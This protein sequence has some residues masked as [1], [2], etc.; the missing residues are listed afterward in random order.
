MVKLTN[1]LAQ[2]VSILLHPLLM[3]IFGLLIIYT[4]GTYISLLQYEAKRIILIVVA[5]NTI[6]LPLLI[7]PLFYRLGFIKNLQMHIHKERILP[8]AFT[9]I[10]YIFSFYFLKRLP[11]PGIISTFMLG[12][13]I[14][15]G[16]S[17]LITFWWKISLHMIGIGGMVGF[18][19][20]F[21][22]RLHTDVLSI[23]LIAAT[24]S[25]FL[26]WSRLQLSAHKPSQVYCGFLTGGLIM[27]LT[28]LLL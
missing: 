5:I 2:I 24:A 1:T 20:A 11:I 21:S 12:A 25:G 9:L 10:P 3:P 27:F 28:L 16:V 8:I 26:A 4:S 13:A 6:A 17:L 19:F 15:V 7:I 18:I 23:I 14:T 22:L